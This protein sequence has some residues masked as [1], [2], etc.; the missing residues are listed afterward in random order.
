[1][2]E[3]ALGKGAV[4]TLNDGLVSMNFIASAAN[5]GF[6]I[7][8]FFGHIPHK[9]AAR[10]NLQHIRPSQRAALLNRLK[11]L[12]NFSRVFRGQ[13]LS[14]FITAG[15]VNNSQRVFIDFVATRKPVVS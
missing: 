13:R 7:F 1:M 10:V 3:Q 5:I 2:A 4:Q 6:V 15:D 9:L 11:G 14:F 8:H 12:R